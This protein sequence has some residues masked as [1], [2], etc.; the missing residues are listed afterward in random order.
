MLLGIDIGGTRMKAGLVDEA[1]AVVRPASVATPGELAPFRAALR[2]VVREALGGARPAA[3]GLGCKGIIDPE[4][5]MVDRLPGAWKFLEGT[6][7]R[8]ALEGL[9]EPGTPVR[10]DNDAK[11]ALAGEMAWG[12]A[13]GVRNALLLTLGTGVGGAILADGRILRGA[14]GVAGH[15]GHLTVEP[16]GPPC[17]CGNRGCLEAMFSAR[18]IEAEAWS[19]AHQGASSPFIDRIRENPQELSCR[20]V[21]AAAAEGDEIASWIVERRTKWLAGALSGLV[22]ALDPEVV[23]LTGQIAEAGEQLFGPLRRELKWR[24]AALTRR[25]IPLV[26]AGVADHTG[27]VGAAGLARLALA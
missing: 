21:F 2:E 11:A 27:V 23:I 25:E 9:I 3:A 7:L 16:D 10:A 8:E 1:G 13:R 15:I 17:M 20:A 5:T 6:Y 22:H 14:S 4:T 19:A 24:T 26:A 12:A 18:P